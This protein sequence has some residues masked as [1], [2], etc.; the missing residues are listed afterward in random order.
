MLMG[1]LGLI[2]ISILDKFID[3]FSFS[4]ILMMMGENPVS[5]KIPILLMGF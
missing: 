2:N 1:F 5:V 4:K 3:V